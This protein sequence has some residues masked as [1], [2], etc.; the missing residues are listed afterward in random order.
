MVLG[1]AL[2][3]M[4]RVDGRGAAVPFSITFCTLDKR[5][6]TG[7]VIKQLKKAVR[8]GAKHSLQRNRQ[9]AVKAVNGTGHPYAIHLRLILRINGEPVV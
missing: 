1:D 5:R 6:G 2:Q 9:I 3:V 8:C 4:D 7:G